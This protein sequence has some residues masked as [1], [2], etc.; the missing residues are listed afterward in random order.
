MGTKEKVNKMIV[1]FRFSEFVPFASRCTDEP[2]TCADYSHCWQLIVVAG[3]SAIPIIDWKF[4]INL[5][6]AKERRKERLA[7]N[8]MKGA[9][10]S[11][12]YAMLELITFGYKKASRSHKS[13]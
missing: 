13:F 3:Q 6:T 8:G 1:I 9:G 2:L 10:S 5:C 12:I 4:R 11:I 7:K